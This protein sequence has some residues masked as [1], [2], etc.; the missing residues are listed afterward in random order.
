MTHASSPTHEYPVRLLKFAS[1]KCSSLYSLFIINEM[2]NKFDTCGQCQMPLVLPINIRFASYKR[3]SLFN[4]FVSNKGKKIKRW[5]PACWSSGQ[6]IRTPRAYR[7]AG[8]NGYKTF[9]IVTYEWPNKL[10]C[11]SLAGLSSLV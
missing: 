11:L 6:R 5:I 2:Y 1:D 9:F 8:A 10:E 7:H 3:S 4:L